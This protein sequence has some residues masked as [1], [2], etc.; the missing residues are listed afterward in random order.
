[1]VTK[2]N[3]IAEL[4]RQITYG[5]IKLEILSVIDAGRTFTPAEIDKIAQLAAKA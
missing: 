4:T 1:V 3:R 2:F 5:G